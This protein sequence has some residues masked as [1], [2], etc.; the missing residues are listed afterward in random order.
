M[1]GLVCGAMPAKLCSNAREGM[2]VVVLRAGETYRQS[3]IGVEGEIV[4]Q[5]R[6]LYEKLVFSSAHPT[7]RNV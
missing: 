5:E 4:S 1:A 6:N 3:D 2:D 7:Q